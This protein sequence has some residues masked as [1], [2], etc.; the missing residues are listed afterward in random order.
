MRERDGPLLER[1]LEAYG[2]VAR[3]QLARFRPGGSRAKS[4]AKRAGRH[5]AEKDDGGETSGGFGD[6]L[7][8]DIG[9]GDSS[10]VGMVLLFKLNASDA[11]NDLLEA[12]TDLAAR[13]AQRTCL[14]AFSLNKT[15]AGALL[16]AHPMLHIVTA[17]TLL[18]DEN[19][20]SS[21][22]VELPWIRLERLMAAEKNAFSSPYKS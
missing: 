3:G 1:A 8:L 16:E 9:Q 22:A 17:T 15:T 6:S 12:V 2:R 18:S 10:G 20:S 14:L 4:P 11:Q 19:D 13:G 5:R 7:P 21:A